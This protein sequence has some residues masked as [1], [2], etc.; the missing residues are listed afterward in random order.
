ML[1]LSQCV[2]NTVISPRDHK[3][4]NEIFYIIFSYKAFKNPVYILQL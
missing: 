4:I 1:Y 3:K 2:K